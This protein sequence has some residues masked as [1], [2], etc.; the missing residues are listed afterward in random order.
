MINNDHVS[1]TLSPAQIDQ[2]LRAASQV[3]TSSV[4]GLIYSALS[5]PRKS[6]G[7]ARS[8]RSRNRRDSAS[9]AATETLISAADPK[10]S[11]SLLRGLS[12]L[13]CF[14]PESGSRGVLELAEMLDMSP[15]TT[16]RY[17]ITLVEVGLLERC[18]NTRRYQL[19]L[20][21]R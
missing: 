11:R 17:V 18:P 16:H 10:L 9:R 1:I 5:T 7:S 4:A 21:A 12:I 14:D 19:P 2:V 15:S 13:T 8:R 20:M 6:S 3:G